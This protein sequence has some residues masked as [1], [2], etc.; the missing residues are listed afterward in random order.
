MLSLASEMATKL[1]TD[2]SKTVGTDLFVGNMPGSPD[3][4]IALYERTGRA[5]I[6][7]MHDIVAAF[8][9][10]LEVRVRNSDYDAGYTQAKLLCSA[11]QNFSGSIGAT[12]YLQ[13]TQLGDINALGRDESSP[14]RWTFGMTFL[15][16]RA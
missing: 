1:G 12:R 11:L 4:A 9:P 13:V 14:S 6:R 2:L 15:V 5:P 7:A 16:M 10:H 8:Q 3:N